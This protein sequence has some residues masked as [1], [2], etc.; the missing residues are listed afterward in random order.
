M[1]WG[2]RTQKKLFRKT[3]SYGILRTPWPAKGVPKRSVL[4]TFLTLQ[5]HSRETFW[6]LRSP[7]PEK[8]WRHPVATLPRTPPFS[9][10]L[11]GTLRGPL[12]ARRARET[13]VAVLNMIFLCWVDFFSGRSSSSDQFIA[14]SF[15]G[16]V[17]VRHVPLRTTLTKA[18][19]RTCSRT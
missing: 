5:G 13:P 11:L 17:F 6:A 1:T 3:C 15:L 4:D 14:W 19:L 7:G 12:R 16:G 8:S 9:G 10:T 18:S 2:S